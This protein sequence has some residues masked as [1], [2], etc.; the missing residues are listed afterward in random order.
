MLH[1]VH[2][3]SDFSLHRA[4]LIVHE[5]AVNRVPHLPSHKVDCVRLSHA[6][7]VPSVYITTPLGQIFINSGTD[8]C[9]AD[10]CG[11]VPDT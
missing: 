7:E 9:G 8:D 3:T 11:D 6:L 2:A 5:G 10:T 1:L 4:S